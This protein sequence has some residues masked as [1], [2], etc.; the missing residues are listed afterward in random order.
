MKVLSVRFARTSW[1]EWLVSGGPVAAAFTGRGRASCRVPSPLFKTVI[2]PHA[3]S[4][5]SEWARG[6][7]VNERGEVYALTIGE[8][9]G[10]IVKVRVLLRGWLPTSVFNEHVYRCNVD[11]RSR[12]LHSITLP[13]RFRVVSVLPKGYR[14]IREG[15]RIKVSW[16]WSRGFKGKVMLR[17]EKR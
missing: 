2:V 11:W 9:E 10:R 4:I 13:P 16:L 1:S 3:L 8:V 5:V 12:H 7:Y 15:K 14:M 17:L 6:V